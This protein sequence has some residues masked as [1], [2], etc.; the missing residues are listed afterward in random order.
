MIQARTPRDSYMKRE[1]DHLDSGEHAYSIRSRAVD[2]RCRTMLEWC[3]GSDQA[4]QGGR[5][6]PAVSNLAQIY[7]PILPVQ[8][9]TQR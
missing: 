2:R 1:G 8:L 9:L 3:A 5:E 7:L 6:D 4:K